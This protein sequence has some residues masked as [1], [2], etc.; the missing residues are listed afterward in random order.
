[1]L[2]FCRH[3]HTLS[4]RD[5]D[6]KLFREKDSNTNL[7]DEKAKGDKEQREVRFCVEQRDTRKWNRHY[8]G[9][10]FTSMDIRPGCSSLDLNCWPPNAALPSRIPSPTQY[11]RYRLNRLQYGAAQFAPCLDEHGKQHHQPSDIRSSSKKG[12]RLRLIVDVDVCVHNSRCQVRKRKTVQEAHVKSRRIGSSKS[13]TEWSEVLESIV[14]GGL[15][16]KNTGSRC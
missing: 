11:G 9:A 16:S 8:T 4:T 6:E 15:C 14:A 13:R 5:D 2:L 12:Q 1:M 3:H 10:E 7:P